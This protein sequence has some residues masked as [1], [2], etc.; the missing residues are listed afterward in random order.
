MKLSRFKLTLGFDWS[1][2]LLPII[3]TGIGTAI[4]FSI[5]YGTNS[6][7][8]L[9]QVMFFVIGL[10]L[11]IFLTLFD[12]RT[13][14]GLYLILYIIGVLLLILVVLIG[15]KSFGATRWID[16]KIFQLQPSELFKLII[17]VVLA[18]FFS[19]W[20][21]LTW[22]KIL[23]VLVL[24]GLPVFLIMRQPDLGTASV[25]FVS[26][27]AVLF[28][29]PIRKIYLIIAL[30]ALVALSPLGWHFL[31]TYQKQRIESFINPA[32]DPHGVGYNVSQAKIAVGS[33]GLWGMGLGKGSQS[34][35]N[36]LPV[37]HT[38]F[39]FAGT[40]EATG[41]FGSTFLILVL[42]T[43]VVRVI[44]VAKIAKD[45][46]GMYLAGGIAAIF[47]FQILVNIG[48]NLGIMP[49]TGIPLPF[50]SSGGSSMITNMAAI[51]ILQSIYLRHKKITF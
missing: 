4:I 34:Q 17:L 48:M 40:A 22:Q 50:V 9:S 27:L 32:N 8:A 44:N 6:G 10:A 23:F 30:A 15:S 13:L 39:I 20:Q 35:L 28:L 5:T 42:M 45:S 43:L 14:K 46:F 49:V 38:D 25:I 47:L 3:L 18:K 37:A 26:L 51:G 12:Y 21:E 19:D 16:L 36:F 31:K 33:G 11:A 24:V 1:L 29:S 41:F 7:L 2:F